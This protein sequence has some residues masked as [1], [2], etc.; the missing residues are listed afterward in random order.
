[1][2][3]KRL[4]GISGGACALLECIVWVNDFQLFGDD[5]DGAG[6]GNHR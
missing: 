2:L 3:G 5:Y 6:V 1:M 4:G